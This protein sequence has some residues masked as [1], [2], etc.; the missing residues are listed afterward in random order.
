MLTLFAVPKPFH[1]PFDRIQRSAIGS[2]MR[3]SPRCEVIL[4]GDEYG[5]EAVAKELGVLHVPAVDRNEYG[6][7]LLHG[8]FARTERLASHPHLCYVNCDIILMSDFTRSAA[9]VAR[10]QKRFLM[11]GE[12]WN[13]KLRRPLAFR[14]GWDGHLQKRVWKGGSPRGRGALDYFVFSRGLYPPLP[15]FAV[16][17]IGFDNWLLW[18]ANSLKAPVVDA[19][20]SVVAVHQDHDYSHVPGGRPWTRRGEE[21]KRNLALAGGE[22]HLHT[23]VNATHW[24]GPNG[25]KV[26]RTVPEVCPGP[27]PA[28]VQEW[29]KAQARLLRHLLALSRS[30]VSRS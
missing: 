23:L 24:L 28:N 3:L 11:V 7:P 20:L 1:G 18:K 15:P 30:C 9:C 12:S 8:L 14:P 5:T 25:L 21:A 26:N 27:V 17:R 16:G 19:S 2:W 4:F 6:A 13:V 10:W 22:R 29:R